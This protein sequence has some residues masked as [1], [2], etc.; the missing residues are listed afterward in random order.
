MAVVTDA[1]VAV[2]GVGRRYC[3]RIAVQEKSGTGEKS[4]VQK[5]AT[6]DRVIQTET[7]VLSFVQGAITVAGLRLVSESGIPDLVR[8]TRKKEDSYRGYGRAHRT[9]C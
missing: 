3:W 6:G 1:A 9:R 7:M 8:Q 2:E 5:I 4:A